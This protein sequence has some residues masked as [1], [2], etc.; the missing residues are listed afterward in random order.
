MVAQSDPARAVADTVASKARVGVGA[1]EEFGLQKPLFALHTYSEQQVPVRSHA[2]EFVGCPYISIARQDS[3]I[4]G[5][6]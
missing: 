1:R 3:A 6:S 4:N 5:V 2:V